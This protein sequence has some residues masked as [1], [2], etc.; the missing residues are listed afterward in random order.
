MAKKQFGK[1]KAFQGLNLNQNAQ[2]PTQQATPTPKEEST[3]T[4]QTPEPTKPE[5]KPQTE[6][7]V[8]NPYKNDPRYTLS[9]ELR[10]TVLIPEQ[11][12]DRVKT[13]SQA[14]KV[15]IKDVFVQALTDYLDERWPEDKQAA[16]EAL[17]AQIEQI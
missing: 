17:M 10:Y 16:F 3:P 13:Y 2:P 7:I 12:L 8:E 14:R 5:S 11:L 9:G 4:K 1:S 6:Q 15:A